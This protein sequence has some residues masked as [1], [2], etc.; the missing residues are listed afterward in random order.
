MSTILKGYDR[1]LPLDSKNKD[2][3]DG[4]TPHRLER[5]RVD[6][7]LTPRTKADAT[8]CRLAILLSPSGFHLTPRTKADATLVDL[9]L[10]SD[11][12]NESGCD[13]S[14]GRVLF[15]YKDLSLTPRP[16]AAATS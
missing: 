7:H 13:G 3:C 16:K 14:D 6:F 10:S 8:R 9:D 1:A 11:S 4:V 5:Y 2:G 15:G 12:K